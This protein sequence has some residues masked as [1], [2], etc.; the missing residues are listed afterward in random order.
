[1]ARGSDTLGYW[2]GR[3]AEGCRLCIAGLKVVVFVSSGCSASCFYCPLSPRRR[4]RGALYAD[5]E[6]VATPLD[7]VDEISAVGAR[8]I[9]ITGGEPLQCI[10]RVTEIVRFVR[11]AFGSYIHIHAYTCG[12]YASTRAIDALSDAWI[13]ELRFHPVNRDVW[14]L[15]SY[16][17]RETPMSVGVEVPALPI[18]PLLKAVVLEAWRRGAEFVNLNELEVTETNVDRLLARGLQPSEDGRVVRGS[19]EAALEVL[20]WAEDEGLDIAIR[21]CTA[22]FKDRVQ[23]ARRLRRKA[24]ALAPPRYSVLDDGTLEIDGERLLPTLRDLAPL[25]RRYGRA[26]VV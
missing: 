25:V 14:N 19:A 3:M 5:E 2:I 16:A 17:A 10:D 22:K 18:P 26:R 4:S 6:P 23:H 7:I 9:S 1:M 20:R 8:G 11:D 21:V 12:L 24:M 13:D 15:V